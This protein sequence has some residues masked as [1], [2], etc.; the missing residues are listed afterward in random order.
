MEAGDLEKTRRFWTEAIGLE[1]LEDRG[2]YIR[3]GGGGGFAIGIEQASPGRVSGAGPEITVRV[4]DVDAAVVRLREL[5]V[6]VADPC[7]QP[8]GARHAWLRDPDGRPMSIYSSG[9]P[10]M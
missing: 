7:D 10:I 9:Q 3:V 8:W 5:G 1:L 2:P 6:E 4:D